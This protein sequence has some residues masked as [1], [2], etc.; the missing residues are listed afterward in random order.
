MVKGVSWRFPVL[1]SVAGLVLLAIA[2]LLVWPLPSRCLAGECE[3]Q[4]RACNLQA[5]RDW[6]QCKGRCARDYPVPPLGTPANQWNLL[7]C[8]ANCTTVYEFA[9]SNCSIIYDACGG[10]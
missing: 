10:Q 4:L 9:Q 3:D 8:K 5:G 2:L 6:S 7:V 1:A